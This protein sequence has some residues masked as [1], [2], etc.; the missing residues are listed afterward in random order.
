MVARL[1]LLL[2][3]LMS[4]GS[5]NAA[6][7]YLQGS[8]SYSA[9]GSFEYTEAGGYGALNLYAH[10]FIATGP[11]PVFWDGDATFLV[12]GDSYDD[13]F[14]TLLFETPLTDLGGTVAVTPFDESYP[15]D[16]S[17]VELIPNWGGCSA[18]PTFHCSDPLVTSVTTTAPAVPLPNT[19]LLVL[20]AAGGLIALRFRQ[21]P[22]NRGQ[23]SVIA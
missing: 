13:W 15:L 22:R 19:A 3:A 9:F 8:S 21:Q 11:F 2:M 18:G 12:A 20:A 16:G 5:A 10:A 4:A 6:T 23:Y 14:L 1:A 17:R 7:W